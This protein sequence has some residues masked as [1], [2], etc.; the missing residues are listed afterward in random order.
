MILSFIRML[1]HYICVSLGFELMEGVVYG[2]VRNEWRLLTTIKMVS[3]RGA[4]EEVEP[5]VKEECKY[6]ENINSNSDPKLVRTDRRSEFEM[7]TVSSYGLQI[8]QISIYWKDNSMDR[9]PIHGSKHTCRGQQNKSAVVSASFQIKSFQVR[10]VKY[11]I[12]L[13]PTLR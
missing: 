5:P 4:R 7:T 9:C 13:D 1:S 6:Q 11:M 8:R 2:G 10:K 12:D 3:T